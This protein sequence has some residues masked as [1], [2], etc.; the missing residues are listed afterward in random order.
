MQYLIL[1]LFFISTGITVGLVAFAWRNSDRELEN[2]R[3]D[4]LEL[5]FNLAR[6]QGRL[7]A[8]L[9]IL[10]GENATRKNN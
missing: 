7:K 5:I 2:L 4:H 8:A 6:E 1:G 3:S 10:E 9:A